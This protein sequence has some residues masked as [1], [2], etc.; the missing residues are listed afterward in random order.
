MDPEAHADGPIGS[1]TFV[2]INLCER[3]HQFSRKTH[4]LV[5]KLMIKIFPKSTLMNVRELVYQFQLPLWLM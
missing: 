3:V 1:G 5:M 4:G 2:L